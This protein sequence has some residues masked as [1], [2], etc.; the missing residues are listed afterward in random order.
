[1]A[2]TV[3]EKM[4]DGGSSIYYDA[5]FCHTLEIFLNALTT[6]GNTQVI[7]VGHELVSRYK[8]DFYGLLGAIEYP[9]PMQLRWITMRVNG[10]TNPNEFVS[11]LRDSDTDESGLYETKESYTI[12][13][14]DATEID[15]IRSRY[16]TATK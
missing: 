16:L 15:N 8:S 11:M 14:P 5:G 4:I 12:L 2:F 13:I 1:M 7:T 10:F 6:S 3:Q 9:V